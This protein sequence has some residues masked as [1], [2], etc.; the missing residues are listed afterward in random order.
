MI[1][2]KTNSI[3]EIKEESCVGCGACVNKCDNYA[4]HI[5]QNKNGFY[6]AIVDDSLCTNCGKCKK[7]CP[8][9]A[10]GFNTHF[11]N[12]KLCVFNNPSLH[13][14]MSATAGGFQIIANKMIE[15]GAHIVGAAW[16]EKWEC[17]Y[18][19]ADRK[20]D[21]KKLYKSKYVQS[22]TDDIYKKTEDKLK[23]GLMVL[24]SGLPCHV[25][26]LY[27]YLG[28]DYDNLYTIDLLCNNVPSIKA[29]HKFLAE[30]CGGMDQVQHI[31]FRYKELGKETND[32][33]LYIKTKTKT[34]VFGSDN[35]YYRAFVERKLAGKHCENCKFGGLPRVG[36]ISLGDIYG[37]EKEDSRFAPLK[38][39]S[40]LINAKKGERLAQ[41]I[42]DECSEYKEISI[43]IIKQ[44]HPI[45]HGKW[46]V[47]P[48]RNQA[49]E[50]LERYSFER[51]CRAVVEEKY[52]VGIVGVATNPNYGGAL[53]YLA[54]KWILEELDKTSLMIIP[55][56]DDLLWLPKRITNFRKNPYFDYEIV[57]YPDK[58]S[59]KELND[60]CDM[61]MVGSDQMFSTH[62]INNGI[63]AECDE[64]ASLDWVF[65]RK[66]KVA[67]AASFGEDSIHCPSDIKGRMAYYLNKFDSFA[68]REQSAIKLCEEEFGIAA[69]WVLD[70]IFLVD[71]EKYLD[72]VADVPFKKADLFSYIL[73]VDDKSEEIIQDI[74]KEKNYSLSCIGDSAI[75]KV[76]YVEEWLESVINAKFIITDSFHCAC[77]A[78]IFNVPFIVIQNKD[79]GKARYGLFHELGLGSRVIASYNE[80]LAEKDNIL[81]NVDWE[82]VNEK[83]KYLRNASMRILREQLEPQ[84]K[85]AS[86]YDILNAKITS[87]YGAL[88]TR[89]T[90]GYDI[91]D[92]RISS[93]NENMPKL[94]FLETVVKRMYDSMMNMISG[95]ECIIFGT[96]DFGKR[97]TRELNRRGAK[98]KYY[99]D[100][101]E[102][103]QNGFFF[104]RKVY[105]PKKLLEED[106]CVVMIAA[107]DFAGDMKRQLEKM[108]LNDGVKILYYIDLGE[109][110]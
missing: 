51:V 45:L 12:P 96:G 20:E 91:L 30:S 74:L 57:C 83:I 77:F 5:R 37:A 33:C 64:F 102:R 24:F 87:G 6:K 14:I 86:D 108:Q 101:D 10:G 40:I 38:T 69:K 31:D 50:M 72:L 23:A 106:H 7:V 81:K 73:D 66:K 67:Y 13:A 71:K 89:I 35:L 39:E 42:K 100:N 1:S 90:S 2:Q 44:M 18:V 28:K 59:M 49:Y 53:T 52:D 63:Y 4:V 75:K 29:F 27:S 79:R 34:Y 107:F 70:P 98:I 47:S 48:K 56:G 105:Y 80:Y 54:L 46:P 32:F 97:C 58:E 104:G 60:K 85:R 22:R 41:Y 110:L 109:E 78:V 76:A 103:K 94:L 92:A 9:L 95:E 11:K 8:L 15:G 43:D 55:P 65:D 68:V 26:G 82:Y 88:D 99:I 19:Y 62:Y 36:D 16:N 3:R 93:I 17:V 21:L 61:F 25:A 84:K